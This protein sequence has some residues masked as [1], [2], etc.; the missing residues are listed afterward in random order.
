MDERNVRQVTHYNLT[1]PDIHHL[2]KFIEEESERC[3]SRYGIKVGDTQVVIH[4]RPIVGRK[5]SYT[6]TVFVSTV[7]IRILVLY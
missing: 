2:E 6:H 7:N 3:K 1:E 4:A 5:Y